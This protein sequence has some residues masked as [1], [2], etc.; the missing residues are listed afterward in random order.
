MPNTRSRPTDDPLAHPDEPGAYLGSQPERQAET[1]PGGVR[2]DDQRIAASQ[3]S[4]GPVVDPDPSE[5]REA[6]KDR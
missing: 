5:P 1:I 3:S 4:P 6:G 2:P